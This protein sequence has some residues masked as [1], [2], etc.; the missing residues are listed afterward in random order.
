MSGIEP[1][2]HVPALDGIRA[3]A[4]AAVLLFH[5]D[6]PGMQG[7]FLGVSVFFT[8]SGFLITTLLLV[9]WGEHSGI[10]LRTFW[11]RRFRRLL[12]ASWFTMALVLV[13][14]LVGVWDT[15]QLR[16]LRGDVPWSMAELVNWHFIASAR[17]YGD[18]FT[19][20]SPLEHFWS[21]AIEQQFYVLLPL[22]LVSVLALVARSVRRPGG[23][24]S[25]RRTLGPLVVVLAVLAVASAVANGILAERSIDRAYFGTDTRAAELLVGA[26]LAC[27][28]PRNRRAADG[29]VRALTLVLGAA[30][31]ATLVWLV[32]T[33]GLG[34]TWLYPWGLLLTSMSTAA[35][36]M[37]VLQ[38][39]VAGRFLALRPMPD[40]GRISYGVYLLHWPVFLWLTPERTGWSTWPLFGVRLGVTLV[41]SVAMFR[42]LERPIRSGVVLALPRPAVLAL[43]GAAVLLLSGTLVVTRDLPPPPDYLEPRAAD[44]LTVGEVPTTATTTTTAAPPTSVTDGSTPTDAPTTVAPPPPVR[45]QRVLFIGDSIA[46]TL[47]DPL[48]EALNARGISAASAV[49]PGCGV[50]TGFPAREDGSVVSFTSACNDAVPL[51]QRDAVA[52][53]GPD[54]VV[55][56]SSWESVDRVVDGVWHPYGSPEAD[57][58]LMRLY[59][60]MVE[61]LT[62]TGAAVAIATMPQYVAGELR[63]PNDREQGQLRALNTLMGDVVARSPARVTT[64]PFAEMI[65]P[66]DPCPSEVDGVELRPRDGVHFDDRAGARW[67]AERLADHIAGVDLGSI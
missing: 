53:F 16:S 42:L 44:D 45:P 52:A 12:P 67:A 35:L 7:G 64:V 8:L 22:V 33:A 3:L 5:G 38:G 63:T 47:E 19:P 66:S 59:D 61:R 54:L 10:S 40:L 34:D 48:I 30:G 36:V 65:C 50:V 14:G 57:A 18:S 6:I 4:V 39:G 23:D 32:T 31:L 17:T 60:E 29:R 49:G 13:M 26:L 24:T 20:P 58:T 9:E 56:L 46:A 28:V 15:E 27:L 37:A 1:L 62:V 21:L 2:G 51:R 11:S 43:S 25:L 55:A 41:A